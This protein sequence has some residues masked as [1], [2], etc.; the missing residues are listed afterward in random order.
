[1][2]KDVSKYNSECECKSDNNQ[3]SQ[4]GD[5]IDNKMIYLTLENGDE[6]AC[7][8]LG[9]FDVEDKEYIA[10][11]PNGEEDVFL[12]SYEESDEG[13]VLTQIETDEEYNKISNAFLGLCE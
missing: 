10:L 12:Y 13:P 5:Y 8:V 2:E 9:I 11:L 4:D 3:N 6:L 7:H 1:M